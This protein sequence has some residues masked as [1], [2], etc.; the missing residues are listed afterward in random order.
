MRPAAQTLTDYATQS[1]FTDP[2]LHAALYDELPTDVGELTAVVRNLLIHYRGGGIQFSGERLD[3]IDHRWIEA[4]LTTDQKR[5]GTPLA[6][7]REPA[8]RIVGCCRDYTLLTVSALRHQGIPARSRIGF[9]VYFA[10]GF[11]YDH[12][13]A[14][15][16]NGDRWVM[17]DAQL[18]PADGRVFD[19][20]DMPTGPFLS[21]AEVWQRIRAG[22]VDA[23]DFGVDPGLPIRGSWFVRNYVFLQLAHLQRDEV[24]L[25]DGW[26]AMAGPDEPADLDLSDEIATLLIAADAGDESATEE[27]ATR[28]AKDPNLRPDNRVQMHSP[29]GAAPVW[30]DLTTRQPIDARGN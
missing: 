29:T 23:D 25:W 7:P 30:I 16:W 27:L 26:G 9:A 19:S 8:D 22:E 24:L 11:N 13:V 15:Y 17:V 21:A 10:E 4:A 5:N 18:D 20:L 28:Y 3:E 14:E 1:T 12:V 2:G 6:T